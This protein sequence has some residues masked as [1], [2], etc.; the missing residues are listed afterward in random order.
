MEKMKIALITTTINIP[1]VLRYYRAIG[2]EVGIFVAGDARTPIG[3]HR[4]CEEIGAHIFWPADDDSCWACSAMIGRN[5]VA[6]RNIAL[7]EALKWGAEIIVTIDD[8]NFPLSTDYFD[9]FEMV[10]GASFTGLQVGEAGW[11]VDSG[12]WCFPTNGRPVGQRGFPQNKFSNSQVS[13]VVDAKVGVATGLILGD[14]DTSA[15]DRISRYPRVHQISE[16]YRS[17]VV[18][19]P[20]A[21]CPFNSQNTAFVRELSPCFLMVPQ[22]KRYDDIFASLVAQRVMRDFGYQLHIGQPF[23]YQQRNAHDL[24]KDLKAEMWG[25]EHVEEF[26]T[27]LDGIS[28]R[29]CSSVLS[30]LDVI[31]KTIPTSFEGVKDLWGAWL[32]DVEKAL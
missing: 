21:R 26:A 19:I 4:L 27:L 5:T 2:P 23:V 13:Y 17:G 3:A 8:D 12:Q 31:S 11:W 20:S 9:R 14:P 6:R 30:M 7:L 24:L 22:F 29:G 32:S 10:L 15:V 25:M 18:V 16:L 28:L 1:E